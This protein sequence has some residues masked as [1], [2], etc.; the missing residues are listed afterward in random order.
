MQSYY[1]CLN[2]AN[3]ITLQTHYNHKLRLFAYPDQQFA[4]YPITY[5]K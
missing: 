5:P 1:K 2:L 4:D 3:N